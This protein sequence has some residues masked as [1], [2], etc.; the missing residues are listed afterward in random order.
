MNEYMRQSRA[1]A[2]VQDFCRRLLDADWEAPGG[3][4]RLSGDLEL[5]DLSGS[6]FFVNARMFLAALAE[7]DGA[8]ATE[9]GNLSRAF[10]RLMF[11]RLVLP[12]KERE[13][14]LREC[15]VINES[16]V[17]ALHIVRVVCECGGLVIRRKKRFRLTKA[18]RKLLDDDRAGELFR[19]LF[20]A[21]FR[22][23]D[24][25]Y[26]RYV[27]DV[28]SIQVAMAV[29]LWRLDAV[30]RDWTPVCGLAEQV[31]LPAVLKE[32]HA[33]MVSPYEKEEWVLSR[34]IL[35]PLCSLGLIERQE[36]GE[37]SFVDADDSIR[38]TALWRKFF[39]FG[40]NGK[41]ITN[42]E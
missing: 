27:R 31:L 23:F 10:V 38:I 15:K 8:P 17:W 36:D 20:I 26:G 32:L 16:D 9:R 21:Y 25:R 5:E 4:L 6:E 33:A 35:N 24:L 42:Y 39:W 30:A 19:K 14:I 11:D 22:R 34:Y 7:E 12:E 18:A 37:F 29:T 41:A 2:A 40:W 28:P 13:S 3:P 1:L